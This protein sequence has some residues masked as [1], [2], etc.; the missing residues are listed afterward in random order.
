M[1]RLQY[2]HI[3]GIV[4]VF[5]LFMDLLDL[6]ITNVALP[7]LQSEFSTSTTTVEW[8]VTGYLLSLAVFIP[9]SGWAGDR[10]GTKRV[11]MFALTVFTFGSLM[12]ALSWSIGALIFF[13]VLQGVGGGMMTPVGTAMLFRAYP[14]SERATASAVLSIP[15]VVAP[16]SGP[17][18]GGYL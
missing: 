7:T 2:K 5:G 4:F 16:A 3:V 12:C 17:V 1:K 6:T 15:A 8:V 14:P 11:F 18:V 13:R 10:F 9:V